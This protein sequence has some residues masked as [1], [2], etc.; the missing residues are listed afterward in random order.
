ML[1]LKYG[2]NVWFSPVA[3]GATV[4]SQALGPISLGNPDQSTELKGDLST[5][6]SSIPI[7]VVLSASAFLSPVNDL[8]IDSVAQELAS[9]IWA[10]ASAKIECTPGMSPAEISQAVQDFFQAAVIENSAKDGSW[11][12][13]ARS[14]ATGAQ[15]RIFLKIKGE[16]A[17]IEIRSTS[18]SLGAELASEGKKCVVLC[19]TQQPS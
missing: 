5:D 13:A 3:S 12:F 14:R 17:R 9:G 15:I 1:K 10:S 4:D 18:P 2:Q 6:N 8:S 7:K 19:A 16:V 11:A